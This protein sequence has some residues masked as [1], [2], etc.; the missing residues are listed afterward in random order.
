MPPRHTIMRETKLP[1]ER[2]CRNLS[3]CTLCW[4]ETKSVPTVLGKSK[5]T[6]AGLDRPHRLTFRGIVCLATVPDGP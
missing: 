4:V 3:K 6:V 2:R 5:Q 1:P